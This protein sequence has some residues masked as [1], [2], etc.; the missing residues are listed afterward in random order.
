MSKNLLKNGVE[1]KNFLEGRVYQASCIWL[2]KIINRIQKYL[3]SPAGISSIVILLIVLILILLN[4]SIFQTDISDYTSGLVTELI[5]MIITICFVQSLF[6]RK[7]EKDMQNNENKQIRRADKVFQVYYAKYVEYFNNIT[8]KTYSQNST[9]NEHFQMSDMSGLY[10]IPNNLLDG[11]VTSSCIELFFCFE[12]KI[13]EIFIEML[14]NIDFKYN[15]EI[16]EI[17]EQFIESSITF[18]PRKTLLN[19]QN[20]KVGEKNMAEE[21]AKTL[22]NEGND[23]YKKYITEEKTPPASVLT[24]Y[25]ILYVL[26]NEE[27]D[28]INRYQKVICSISK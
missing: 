16:E 14:N 26:L 23:F 28:I 15:S 13:R 24:P 25:L 2:K 19:A 4:Q 5:G 18:D 20:I 10:R 1:D 9:L 3:K 12:L 27:K 7:N 6:D 21:D 22:E 11:L 8:S 17:L